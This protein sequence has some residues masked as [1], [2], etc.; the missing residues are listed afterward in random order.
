M[1][2]KNLLKTMRKPIEKKT[3]SWRQY[4]EILRQ[5]D[6]SHIKEVY[7][8][9]GMHETDI[10]SVQQTLYK[11][12]ELLLENGFFY[13]DK[14]TENHIYNL[15]SIIKEKPWLYDPYTVEK[16]D[17]KAVEELKLESIQKLMDSLSDKCAQ[18]IIF[19]SEYFEF[20]KDY[21]VE[22]FKKFITELLS[23]QTHINI[24]Y[25]TRE[26]ISWSAS[27]QQHWLRGS[28]IILTP[29]KRHDFLTTLY[30]STLK[31]FFNIFDN[32][33]YIIYKFEESI[34]TAYGPAGLFLEKIGFPAE[35]LNKLD[36]VNSNKGISKDV[37]NLLRYINKTSPYYTNNSKIQGVNEKQGRSKD[38]TKLLEKIEGSP[39]EH[40]NQEKLFIFFLVKEDIEWLKEKTGIDYT[41]FY[42]PSKLSEKFVKQLKEKYNML[43]PTLKELVDEYLILRGNGRIEK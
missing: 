20:A 36:I 29:Y 38:D 33:N 9:I 23:E 18:K 15:A 39:F 26:P 21:E 16:L 32:A 4:S 42:K 28:G 37:Y 6:L 8:H 3:V 34:N 25:T 24:V 22:Q 2:P 43:T 40:N 10:A 1:N 31:R 11:N 13:P 27:M 14:W 5:K 30:S 17:E 35:Q 19:S 41:D 12:R 7:I